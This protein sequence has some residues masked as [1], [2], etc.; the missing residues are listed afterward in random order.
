MN[1][2][3]GV[4]VTGPKT[5]FLGTGGGVRANAVCD[6]RAGICYVRRYKSMSR[7]ILRST[8][9]DL[10]LLPELLFDRVQP[11]RKDGPEDDLDRLRVDVRQDG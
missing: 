10:A 9:C 2:R 4:G 11:H 8:P 1:R 5:V 3:F 7:A 6:P